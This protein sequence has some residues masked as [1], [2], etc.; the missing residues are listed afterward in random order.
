MTITSKLY[1]GA[2]AVQMLYP[3]AVTATVLSSAFDLQDIQDAMIAVDV[4]AHT[5]TLDG[6]DYFQ[7]EIQDSPDN[8]T[9]TAVPDANISNPVAAQT[10]TGTMALLNANTNEKQM[11]LAA[12]RGS[13]RYLKVNVRATGTHSSGTIIGVTGY[14]WLNRA[15]PVNAG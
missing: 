11:Y 3:Q 4:G 5:D 9:Y 15:Q 1:A 2:K 12:Y 7:V 10:A 13:N 8:V 6:S 14:G